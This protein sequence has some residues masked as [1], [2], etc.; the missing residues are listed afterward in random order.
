MMRDAKE[1]GLITADLEEKVVAAGHWF[2][3]EVPDQLSE[4]VIDWLQRKFPVG[5]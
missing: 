2:L 3:Y 4:I 5:G 1:A